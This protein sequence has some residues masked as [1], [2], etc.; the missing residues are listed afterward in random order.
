M[1]YD[2][3]ILLNNGGFPP[4]LTE[5]I[6]EFQCAG[7]VL[8]DTSGD[9][10]ETYDSSGVTPLYLAAFKGHEGCVSALLEQ[11]KANIEAIEVNRGTTALHAAAARGFVPVVRLLLSKG[12]NWQALTRHGERAIDLARKQGHTEVVQLLQL[13]PPPPRSLSGSPNSSLKRLNFFE[14]VTSLDHSANPPVLPELPSSPI[15]KQR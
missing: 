14:G 7:Q 12:A 10:T 11:R 2:P 15:K 4:R 6:S 1:H 13:A 8:L 5:K 9:C 3:S